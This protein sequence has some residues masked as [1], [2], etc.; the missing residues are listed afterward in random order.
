MS[1]K[2]LHEKANDKLIVGWDYDA[3]QAAALQLSAIYRLLDERL[4]EKPMTTLVPAPAPVQD[5]VDSLLSSESMTFHCQ[6]HN[7]DTLTVG[8][9][10]NG[11]YEFQ[12][13]TEVDDAEALVYLTAADAKRLARAILGST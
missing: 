4:P 3:D 8:V 11:Q 13:T 1:H 9:I 12:A 10:A 5:V 2:E 6:S 7:A